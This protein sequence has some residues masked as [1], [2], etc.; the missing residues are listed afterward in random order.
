MPFVLVDADS[1]PPV[2]TVPESTLPAVT[3][4]KLSWLNA[5]PPPPPLFAP[6]SSQ[7]PPPAPQHWILTNEMP[8]GTVHVQAPGS[9]KV[10][11]P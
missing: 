8:P 4:N 5:P 6:L 11:V 2:P 10:I 3:G 9:E 7:V 1:A